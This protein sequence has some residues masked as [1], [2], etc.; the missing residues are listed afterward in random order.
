MATLDNKIKAIALH[1]EIP[2]Y[3]EEDKLTIRPDITILDPSCMSIKKQTSLYIRNGKIYYEKVPKVPSKGF[4]F[5]G[6]AI[7]VEIKFIRTRGGITESQISKFEADVGKLLNLI[8]RFNG[9]GNNEVFG[10]FVVFNKT[11]K[12]RNLFE[13]FKGNYVNN[14]NLEIIYGSGKLE[15]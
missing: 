15:I 10:I 12:G 3:D 11:D 5:S 8:Q 13:H 7:A 2:W 6:K 14:Q 9:T 1:T 4:S